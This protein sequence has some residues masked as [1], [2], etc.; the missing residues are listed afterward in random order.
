MTYVNLEKVLFRS[1]C[2]HLSPAYHQRVMW[3]TRTVPNYSD[4]YTNEFDDVEISTVKVRN[5]TLAMLGFRQMTDYE[6]A[7]SSFFYFWYDDYHRTVVVWIDKMH[8]SGVS[9][10][11]YWRI[12]QVIKRILNTWAVNGGDPD[13]EME[14]QDQIHKTASFWID[15]EILQP[16]PQ[17][18]TRPTME[19]MSGHPKIMLQ[20]QMANHSKETKVEGDFVVMGYNKD[21]IE[22]DSQALFTEIVLKQLQQKKITIDHDLVVH[23]L[24]KMDTFKELQK[25]LL[26][27]Y[28]ATDGTSPTKTE[29]VDAVMEGVK[30]RLDRMGKDFLVGFAEFLKGASADPMP[31]TASSDGSTG[32]S[33]ASSAPGDVLATRTG[34]QVPVTT[35]ATVMNFEGA[36]NWQAFIEYVRA[37]EALP[38]PYQLTYKMKTHDLVYDT[39]NGNWWIV[40]HKTKLKSVNSSGC[41]HCNNKTMGFAKCVNPVC[42][43]FDNYRAE[44]KDCWHCERPI[45][46]CFKCVTTTGPNNACSAINH[47]SD[48]I[49][50]K[51]KS[52]EE[53]DIAPGVDPTVIN[54]VATSKTVKR[55]WERVCAGTVE[56]KQD[57][58]DALKIVLRDEVS[59]AEKILDYLLHINKRVSLLADFRKLYKDA[60]DS[61]AELTDRGWLASK[62]YNYQPDF[63]DRMLWYSMAMTRSG[64]KTN[65]YLQISFTKDINSIACMLINRMCAIDTVDTLQE[66]L[67]LR[68]IS[69]GIDNKKDVPDL[70]LFWKK[71]VATKVGERYSITIQKRS[72]EALKMALPPKASDQFKVRVLVGQVQRKTNIHRDVIVEGKPMCH[73]VGSTVALADGHPMQ[74]FLDWRRKVENMGVYAAKDFKLEGIDQQLIEMNEVLILDKEG[75]AVLNRDGAACVAYAWALNETAIVSLHAAG[76]IDA[77]GRA[78]GAD[79]EQMIRVYGTAIDHTEVPEAAT[80]EEEINDDEAYDKW[81]D[82]QSEAAK[83]TI[84]RMMSMARLRKGKKDDDKDLRKEVLARGE[85]IVMELQSLMF[86]SFKDGKAQPTP[87]MKSKKEELMKWVDKK[88]ENP[89]IASLIALPA[90]DFLM[91]KHPDWDRKMWDLYAEAFVDAV[92]VDDSASQDGDQRDDHGSDDDSDSGS[93]KSSKDY[94]FGDIFKAFGSMFSAT[95]GGLAAAADAIAGGADIPSTLDGTA[96]PQAPVQGTTSGGSDPGKRKT[97]TDISSVVSTGKTPKKRKTTTPKDSDTTDPI[98]TKPLDPSTVDMS[99]APKPKLPAPIVVVQQADVPSAADQSSTTPAATADADD[100]ANAEE[101]EQQQS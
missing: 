4:V 80:F 3:R 60:T 70:H 93:T 38:L 98:A 6:D 28:L 74:H 44:D 40:C 61:G 68:S 21:K 35:G 56:A 53:G 96:F 101:E 10:V 100:D 48:C 78:R 85:T 76:K 65:K 69:E 23:H 62:K 18:W 59:M 83:S 75:V 42:R 47:C 49:R 55:M 39:T 9:G 2:H 33:S 66:R 71:A 64:K 97:H 26:Q 86:D 41:H 77:F 72:E 25:Q 43:K 34:Y 81:L 22:L 92:D 51:I 36:A 16:T 57:G 46:R 30:E 32:A 1:E 24:V 54:Y 95:P 63:G 50:D 67:N 82:E 89:F 58:I 11:T 17:T 73:I 12:L 13:N 88:G 37:A 84:A 31:K 94:E 99:A 91:T 90:S 5:R 15:H 20:I 79:M 87:A 14:L 7:G 29:V 45:P 27:E 8:R 19:D 52:G